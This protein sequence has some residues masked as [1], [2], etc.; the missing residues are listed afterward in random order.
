MYFATLRRFYFYSILLACSQASSTPRVDVPGLGV[1]VGDVSKASPEIAFFKGIPYAQPPVKA[2]RWQPPFLRDEPLG[3]GTQPFPAT[4]FG[5]EC[6]QYLN[7]DI[8]GDEDCLFL[9]VACPVSV[10]NQSKHKKLLPVL[11]WIHGGAYMTGSSSAPVRNVIDIYAN[12]AF[13]KAAGGDVVVVSVNYRLIFF[14][15]LFNMLQRRM[16]CSSSISPTL[17]LTA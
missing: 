16:E 2:L 8:V 4:T 15:S 14:C 10:M 11:L 5:A 7:G 13:V 12:D 3:N 17:T 9:N 6:M 1:L